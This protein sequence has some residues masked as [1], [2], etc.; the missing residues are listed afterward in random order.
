M[1][2]YPADETFPL[3]REPQLAQ[4]DSSA[5]TGIA[6]VESTTDESSPIA[7]LLVRALDEVRA[8]AM[9]L[10]RQGKAWQGE[11][12]GWSAEYNPERA[13]RPLDSTMTFTPTEVPV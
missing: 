12:F 13:E 10:H 7:P 8:A 1:D 9:E 4:L 6:R 3:R 2:A 11:L 5:N